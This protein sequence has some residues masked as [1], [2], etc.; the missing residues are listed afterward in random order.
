MDIHLDTVMS[1]PM[2]R[3]AKLRTGGDVRQRPVKWVSVIEMPVEDF[4]REDELVLTTA[5]GC[6]S[7]PQLLEALVEQVVAANAAALGIAIGCYIKEIP[8][9]VLSLADRAHFPL[10][11][12]PWEVRFSEVA[13]AVSDA[14]RQEEFGTLEAAQQMQSEVLDLTLRG[15]NLSEV[16]ACLARRL[17]AIALV[18]DARGDV[19]GRCARGDRLEDLLS[20]TGVAPAGSDVGVMAQISLGELSAL[21]VPIRSM[22]HVE[23]YLV[24]ARPANEV[25]GFSAKHRLMLEHASIACAFWFLQQNAARHAEE[26]FREDFV[27]NLAKGQLGEDAA[28]SKGAA[29]GYRLDAGHSCIVGHPDNLD[30]AGQ[31]RP[32]FREADA[33][34]RVRQLIAAELTHA[35][36]ALGR[37]LMLTYQ[38]ETFLLYLEAEP[39]EGLPPVDRFLDR[40]NRR[41]REVLPDL[42]IS[43]GVASALTGV[44]GFAQGYQDA[45]EALEIGYRQ[46]GQGHRTASRDVTLY[47]TLM[48]LS[49]DSEVQSLVSDALSLL[50]DYDRRRDGALIPTLSTFIRTRGQISETARLLHL[51]RQSL[52]YRLNKIESL[53][54]RSL[55][56]PETWFL[57]SFALFLSSV[58]GADRAGVTA[59][60]GREPREPAPETEDLG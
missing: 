11:E 6:G 40:V 42:V 8:E 28:L 46:N 34:D 59:L 16:A 54:G 15:G 27:W 18:V 4:V 38:R 1:F 12:I 20:Q 58:D 9:S 30:G 7:D 29:L 17:D 53:T 33:A 22:E 55:T 41:L 43:W 26:R 48:H 51:H 36:D 24:V 56:D 14:L 44:A 21:R 52:I 13:Q 47:R 49:N 3:S 35:A 5:M 19:L 23:G 45:R 10:I 2:L 32:A 37:R 39:D 60:M 25:P 50:V 31:W 57:F